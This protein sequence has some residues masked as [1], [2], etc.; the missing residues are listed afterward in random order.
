MDDAVASVEKKA[1]NKTGAE[2]RLLKK[3]APS[4]KV[5]NEHKKAP[6]KERKIEEPPPAA[7]NADPETLE[8]TLF[9]GNV[10]ID[11]IN[12]VTM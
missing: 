9:V 6:Q 1:L 2:Q 8:R 3:R 10:P 12:K 7:L 4:E 5:Q 11:C